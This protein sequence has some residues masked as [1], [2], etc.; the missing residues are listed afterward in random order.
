MES[1]IKDRTKFPIWV[2]PWKRFSKNPQKVKEFHKEYKFSSDECLQYVTALIH[3]DLWEIL[4]WYNKKYNAWQIPSGKVNKWEDMI[5][6]LR[7]EI[8]EETNLKIENPKYLGTSK[9]IL[10]WMLRQWHFFKSKMQWKL[11]AKEIDLIEE[12]ARIK[13]I[14]TNSQLW[15][16][17][18]IWNQKIENPVQ[19]LETWFMFVEVYWVLNYPK[20]HDT[21]KNL[22]IKIPTTYSDSKNYIQ[23]LDTEKNSFIIEE[24]ENSKIL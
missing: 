2:F 9:I 19:I 18:K 21:I 12:F 5:N 14:K 20:Y 22:E 11:Q 17:I 8:K 10:N 24:F 15:F 3:N 6:A 16:G 1:Q 4:V 23:Y 13:F 7:R